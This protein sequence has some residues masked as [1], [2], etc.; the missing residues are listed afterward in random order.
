MNPR[1][2]II[3]P[4][5]F[6]YFS[7][8]P[9]KIREVFGEIKKLNRS[10]YSSI[11]SIIF[12]DK[13]DVWNYLIKAY[14]IESS[15]SKWR[16]DITSFLGTLGKNLN[17]RGVGMASFC[18]EYIPSERYLV[19]DSLNLSR[20]SPLQGTWGNINERFLSPLSFGGLYS[21]GNPNELI[22]RTKIMD[23]VQQVRIISGLE[24]YSLTKENN[25]LTPEME[26]LLK[27]SA[28]SQ[29]HFVEAELFL[30]LGHLFTFSLIDYSYFTSTSSLNQIEVL[31]INL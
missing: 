3:C 19:S 11:D 5:T 4:Y 2:S 10:L 28:V 27:I 7:K 26:N 23:R 30:F 15:L 22:D 24:V 12:Q 14:G 16:S 9:K 31:Q 6:D 21:K 17:I 13:N 1:V 20:I 25:F 8:N 18:K 29:S